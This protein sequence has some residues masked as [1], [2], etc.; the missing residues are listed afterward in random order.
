M[1]AVQELPMAP[2]ALD[3]AE[4][5]RRYYGDVFRFCARRVGQDLAA[6][7]AQET[8]LTAQRVQSKFRGDSTA[9]TWLLGI[10]HN[11]CR[12]L[13]RSKRRDPLP[14]LFSPPNPGHEESS[15]NRRA[16]EQALGTLSPL[17]REAVILHELDQL[18]YEEAAAVL[19][20]PVGTVKSRLHNAFAQ[21]RQ[22]L[23][24]EGGRS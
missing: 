19:G 22:T 9:K 4:A 17:L 15:V 6:D 7:A 5:A 3:L 18:T 20:V 8:F 13:L 14:I 2:G 11:E 16:L 12:N 23:S 10:A 1:Q 24:A 21:L